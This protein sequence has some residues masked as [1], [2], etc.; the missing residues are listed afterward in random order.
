M[1]DL[2]FAVFIVLYMFYGFL[3]GFLDGTIR[4]AGLILMVLMFTH[5]AEMVIERFELS[6][7]MPPFAEK[8]IVAVLAVLPIYLV[9]LLFRFGAHLIPDSTPGKFAGIFIGFL[10]GN[11]LVIMFVY[12]ILLLPEGSADTFTRG[13]QLYP[14]YSKATE[15][16]AA[17][18]IEEK[19]Q[20]LGG[21]LGTE[22][23]SDIDVDKVM[24]KVQDTATGAGEVID[25]VMDVDAGEVIEEVQEEQVAE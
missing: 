1:I 15:W 25:E 8:T 2:L 3:N 20:F 11:V 4:L 19:M 22:D 9:S 6:F 12:V 13:S 14:A 17:D 23:L 18:L 10:R 21:N 5:G 16:L 7:G 24:E